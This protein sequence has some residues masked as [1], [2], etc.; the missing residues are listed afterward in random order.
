MNTPPGAPPPAPYYPPPSPANSGGCWKAAGITCAV[1]IVLGAIA[2]FFGVRAVKDAMHHGTGI[3][4]Q[5]MS[6]GTTVGNGLK[7]QRAVVQYHK[8]NGKYP[9][10]LMALVSDGQID[11][12]LLHSRLD[13][14][15]S[16]GHISWT[17]TKPSEGAPGDTPI[18]K[19]HYHISIPGANSARQSQDNDILINLDGTTSSNTAYHSHM[20]T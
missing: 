9:A 6:L 12:K 11:G 1:L 5:A 20:G 7:L 16:P 2:V 15:P 18:L 13:P 8:M 4:G 3:F 10:S 17:Y 19:L 14:D